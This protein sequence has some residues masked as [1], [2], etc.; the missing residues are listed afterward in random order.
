MISSEQIVNEAD[1]HARKAKRHGK[2]PHFL[3]AL[4][5]DAVRRECA[6]IPFLGDYVP[7]G[8]ERLHVG[9]TFGDHHGSGTADHAYLLVDSSGFGGRGELAMTVSQ[10]AEFVQRHPGY[11]Y[12]IIEA[13]QFQIVLG[14][15]QVKAN[16][17]V[18]GV[19]TKLTGK[20]ADSFK[21]ELLGA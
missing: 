9:E 13:G 16:T 12:G 14:V 10:F 21:K 18:R 7:N 11:G 6:R 15:Y 17:K 19:H 5:D 1:R 4:G 2:Q 3:S 20:L 8:Y